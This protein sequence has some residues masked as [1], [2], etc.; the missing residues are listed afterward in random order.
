[1]LRFLLALFLSA[2][3]LGARGP[4]YVVLWFDT[5][6]YI[7]PAADD[8]ALRLATDLDK[9][10]VRATFKVVGEKARV[11]E[12]R[13]R[14]DVIRAL[15]HHDVGYHSNYHSMQPTPALYLKD[16]GWLEGAAEFQRREQSGVQDIRRVFGVL[17]S[18]YGQPGSSWGP[19]SYPALM[20]MGI[21]VYLD[22]GTQVGI[23]NQPFWF[24]GMLN[25]FHMG[26]YAM[27][28]NL[29]NEGALP[30][31]LERFD[32]AVDELRA[33][34]GGVISSYFHPTEF[35]S[36]EF[37]DAVN[38]A[39]GA[40]P[41]RGEWRLQPLR[42]EQESEKR[43]QIMLRYV[44]H[45]KN[46]EDV[47]FVTARQVPQLYR[48]ANVRSPDRA[49]IAAHM[50]ARQ[51]FL[52][53][54]GD[55]LSAADMLLALLG[56][57]P[58]YVD[59]PSENGKTTLTTKEIARAAFERAK[60]E[61]VSFIRMHGRLPAQVWIGSETLKLGDFTATLAADDGA[62]PSISLRQGNA[63][64]EKYVATDPARPFSWVIHPDGFQAPHLLDLARLQAWTLKPAVLR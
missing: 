20:R 52:V 4:V 50:A 6:D 14:T 43:F 28:P 61:A 58:Q 5:E 54:D 30:G 25:V 41:E 12:S 15:A 37:W 63:E 48:S 33:R 21:P 35:I 51:T 44:E 2:A 10:G 8:A 3:A 24:G 23:D 39:H 26:S 53:A 56:M 1:M 34:G 38:F 22:E 55:S 17:P 36:A 45:A 9:M 27:R 46:T 13:G 7:E 49:R 40:N 18:C 11:L 19:Q 64:M 16:M 57:E 47:R 42:T 59:G 31:F 60:A 32:H 62:S 29:D